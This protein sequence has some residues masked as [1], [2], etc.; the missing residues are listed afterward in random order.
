MI[1]D[2]AFSRSDEKK[3][4]LFI[5]LK[6]AYRIYLRAHTSWADQD[7]QLCGKFRDARP[8]FLNIYFPELMARDSEHACPD[9]RRTTT[10]PVFFPRVIA[11]SSTPT[12]VQSAV[13]RQLFF[14]TWS[15]FEC[16]GKRAPN[17]ASKSEHFRTKIEKHGRTSR[18]L[19][20]DRC[21]DSSLTHTKHEF[22]P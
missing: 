2:P 10:T 1:A 5:V 22:Q 6:K 15:F 20:Q 17:Q 14:L 4:R 19:H 21:A 3:Y 18:Y 12:D 7:S 9:T 13:A 8:S 11:K 16:L